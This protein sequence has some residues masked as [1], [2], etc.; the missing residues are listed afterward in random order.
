MIATRRAD[1][2]LRLG[3]GRRAIEGRP[4]RSRERRRKMAGVRPQTRRQ[5]GSHAQTEHRPQ[6]FWEWDLVLYN[7]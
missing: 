4:N 5:H 3:N 2:G 6:E 7:E 1:Q